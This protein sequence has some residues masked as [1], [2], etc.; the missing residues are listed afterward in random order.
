MPDVFNGTSFRVTPGI[1]TYLALTGPGSMFEGSQSPRLLEI[2]DGTA[3]TVAVVEANDTRA[4][5]WSCPDDLVYDPAAPING[6]P[7]HH[8]GGF[9]ALTC[10]GAVHFIGETIDP[11][12]LLALFT[13]NGGERV[14]VNALP[15]H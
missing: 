8:P 10:D 15:E 12:T 6:L 13:F 7:G 3:N 11:K 1:T 9:L 4:V 5:P 2:R 14:D